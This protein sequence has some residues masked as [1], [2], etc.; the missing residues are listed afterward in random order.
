MST[1]VENP[2]KQVK[3]I[4]IDD[5]FFYDFGKKGQVLTAWGMGGARTFTESCSLNP[6]LK[7][8]D[9][10]KKKYKVEQIEL[11]QRVDCYPPK[12]LFKLR[13][14]LE[15][16]CKKSPTYHTAYG[17]Q[18]FYFSKLNLVE[19]VSLMTMQIKTAERNNSKKINEDLDWYF[20]VSASTRS[21]TPAWEGH[22]IGRDHLDLETR[23][24]IYK[25]RKH[26]PELCSGSNS[27]FDSDCPF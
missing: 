14:R 15:R 12:A 17:S 4:M 19:Q 23:L 6:I 25:V 5:R 20:L 11:V 27:G 22:L 13:Y 8:L 26:Y 7:K 10:K 1:I 24:Q 21:S 9:E 2:T 18:C 3:V 16:M